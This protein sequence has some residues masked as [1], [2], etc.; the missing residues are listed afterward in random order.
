MMSYRSC[1]VQD[2]YMNQYFFHFLFL[3]LITACQS[4]TQPAPLED[5]PPVVL[6]SS[7]IV[8][9]PFE[10]A[11]FDLIGMPEAIASSDTSPGWNQPG[12]KL[13]VHGTIYHNDRQTPAP[14][15]LLYYYHTDIHGVYASR[16]E[17]DPRVVRHGYI[18]GWV[19]SDEEGHYALYT[20]RPAP[21]PNTDMPAHIHPSIREPDIGNAYYIDE[22]VFDDDPLLTPEKRA[23]L[24]DRGGSGILT[25]VPRGDG[26][27]GAQHDIILG[28]NIPG[29]PN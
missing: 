3:L 28:M 13:L 5:H 17:L 4:Q 21:Y 20:V 8:G 19:K 15:V 12:Q 11:D 18:R 22:F 26:L 24:P 7:G 9:G 14:G 2:Y 16:E 1:S 6:R 25:L 10:N 23:D 29:Y 27:Q